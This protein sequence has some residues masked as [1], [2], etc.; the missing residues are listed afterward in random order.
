MKQNE[1]NTYSLQTTKERLVAMGGA[2]TG[3]RRRV[4]FYDTREE[5]CCSKGCLETG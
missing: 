1:I 2:F 4:S 3:L 5:A